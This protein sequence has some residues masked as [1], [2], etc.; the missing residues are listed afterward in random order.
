MFEEIWSIYNI[1][2]VSKFS[3]DSSSFLFAVRYKHLH[4][5]IELLAFQA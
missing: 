4:T 1:V 2:H 5:G 3:G